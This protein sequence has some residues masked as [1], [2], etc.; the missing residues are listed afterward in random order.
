M[1]IHSTCLVHHPLERVYLAYR[2]ELPLMVPFIPDIREIVVKSREEFTGGV[3]ILNLWIADREPPRAV[4]SVIKKEWLQW[5]DYATWNDE[6][7]FVDWRMI[8]PAMPD[9][10]RCSGRNTFVKDGLDRTK[11]II[12][13]ELLIDASGFPGVPSSLVRRVGTAIEAFIVDLVTPNLTRM[14]QS[15]E[16]YLD[17]KLRQA[18]GA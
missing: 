9:R 1:Q 10:M 2:D 15:L 7:T 6:A 13:G 5:E 14:N 17:D 3:K 18:A 11:V 4:A 8:L 16:L 12:T